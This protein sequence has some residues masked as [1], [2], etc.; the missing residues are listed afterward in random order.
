MRIKRNDLRLGTLLAATLLAAGVAGSLRAADGD[1]FRF[2][3]DPVVVQD[4][5]T[6]VDT[7]SAKLQEYRDLNPGLQMPKF[8]LFGESA[9]GQRTLALRLAGVDRED[10]RYQ[11]D[12][13]LAGSWSF[14]L[15]YNKIPHRF[16]NDGRMLFTRTG[17]GR[18]EIA[19]PVQAAIQGVLE[20]TTPRSAITF[21]F[22]NN[23]LAP[24]LATESDVD[25]GLRRDRTYARVDFLFAEH[26]LVVEVSGRRGHASDAE[27]AKDAQRRN[28]LTADG[29]RFLEFTTAQVLDGP[30]AVARTV[31]E[32]LA[33]S[34]AVSA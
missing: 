24:Y 27:R 13:G 34:P 1:G 11:L 12:Y 30:A 15:D 9:D 14:T 31:A 10:A 33:R 25:L 17:P 29:L 4:M 5:V 22:L 8:Q 23:L 18:Y 28:E 32:Q 6:E 19:D 21:F 16:G 20:K 3:I 7:E 26:G 2:W